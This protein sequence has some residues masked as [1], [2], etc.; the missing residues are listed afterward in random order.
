MGVGSDDAPGLEVLDLLGGEAELLEDLVG[1]L[2]AMATESDTVGFIGGMDVPLIRHFACG[3]A[4]GAKAVNPDI[5][6]LCHGGPIS[7]P[8]ICGLILLIS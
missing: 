2:A 6:V 1:M 5:M 4:Q 3:Y 8:S 7:S